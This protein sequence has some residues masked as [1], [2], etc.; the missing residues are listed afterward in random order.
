MASII[1]KSIFKVEKQILNL[2]FQHL[3]YAVILNQL[4]FIEISD[5]NQLIYIFSTH[6]FPIDFNFEAIKNAQLWSEKIKFHLHDKLSSFL[7]DAN[8]NELL[9]TTVLDKKLK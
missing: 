9:S 6:T 1:W 8:A 7:D 2:I 3:V 4:Q 5:E